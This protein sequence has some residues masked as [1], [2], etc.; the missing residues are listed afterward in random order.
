MSGAKGRGGE[1]I[2]RHEKSREKKEKR[3]AL[4]RGAK[5]ENE[6]GSLSDSLLLLF[7]TFCSASRRRLILLPFVC[8][9]PELIIFS[10]PF[11]KLRFVETLN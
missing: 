2:K 10:A 8:K 3:K 9:Y 11:N 5:D 4:R 6:L 7:F 1:R